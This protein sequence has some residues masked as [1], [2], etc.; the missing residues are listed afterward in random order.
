MMAH[1]I[2]EKWET[3]YHF[4]IYSAKQKGWFC[5]VCSEFSEGT[6]HW[7]TLVAKL[8]QHP[9][10]TFEGHVQL[11]KHTNTILTRQE[12]KQMLVKGQVCKQMCDGERKQMVSTKE[13]NRRVIKKVLKTSYLIV[14]KKWA[15]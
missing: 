12:V 1:Q 10:R 7:I 4:A 5:K 6:E 14:K 2:Q 3:S 13:R 9:T 15:L 8:N 11:R